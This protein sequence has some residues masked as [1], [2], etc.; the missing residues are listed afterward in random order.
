MVARKLRKWYPLAHQR[1]RPEVLKLAGH[2]VVCN[3]CSDPAV[4][5]CAYGASQLVEAD[6]ALGLRKE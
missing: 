4:D 3:T 6:I 1:K 2:M 5:L